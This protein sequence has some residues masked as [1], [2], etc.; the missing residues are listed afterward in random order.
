MPTSV[1]IPPALLKAV[2]KK[3]RELKISRN[4]LVIQALEKEVG[5][6]DKGWPPGFFEQ[7][8]PAETEEDKGV[9]AEFMQSMNRPRR[10]RK[11]PPDL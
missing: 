7:F 10:S 5:S 9:E 1:H 11:P 6:Q 4:R 2:D 8:T 3:A